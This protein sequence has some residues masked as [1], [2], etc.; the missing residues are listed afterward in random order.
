MSSYY[1]LKIQ[2][3][4]KEPETRNVSEPSLLLGRES[5]DVVLGDAQSSGRHAEI[6]FD[7]NTVQVK[8]L[9]STNGTWFNGQRVAQFNLA[10]GEWFQIGQSSLQ[11]LAV[12]Q[13]APAEPASAPAGGAKTM[14]AFGGVAPPAPARGPSSGP[15][16]GPPPAGAAWG[17]PP[18]AGARSPSAP[19]PA[20][21][22]AAVAAPAAAAPPPAAVA[23]APSP[24]A[25]PVPAPAIPAPTAAAPVPAPA[26]PAPA[27]PAPAAAG[28]YVPQPAAGSAGGVQF[29]FHGGGAELL[30]FYLIHGWLLMMVTLGLYTPWFICKLQAL[31]H[32]RTTLE[33]TAR[34]PL[35]LSFH[36]RG[37]TLFGLGLKFLLVPLSL[38]IYLPWWICAALRFFTDNNAAAAADGTVYHVRFRGTGGELF[39][40]IFVPAVLTVVTFGL[41]GPW[42]FCS[43]GRALAR[44]MEVDEDG[45]PVGTMDFVGSGAEL[46][47]Q[48][49]L[50]MVL[51]IPTLTLYQFWF[52]MKM[53]RFLARGTRV[54]V[55]GRTFGGDFDG[56]GGQWLVLNLLGGFLS[57]ITFMLYYP[58][59]IVKLIEFQYQ[60]T[61][62]R[63]RPAS[64]AF[65]PRQPAVGG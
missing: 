12:H 20:P 47:V 28:P 11:L 5:G 62:F 9:D 34:G 35:R 65:Q 53:Q 21:P 40:A 2:Y 32:N 27:I 50:L 19:F 3:A 17:P 54:L 46:F 30:V 56:K 6:H 51:L 7:G 13:P 48:Y 18:P 23:A 58:W 43:I 60:Y 55:H 25:A 41:Y 1:V 45:Q 57:M 10:P 37:G 39:G 38:G 26:I 61:S 64:G 15:A 14:I 49:L 33:G 16:A 63:E 42:A 4:N 44:Q 31:L 8:D 29:Q 22:S 59:F 24:A 36:G 52:Q